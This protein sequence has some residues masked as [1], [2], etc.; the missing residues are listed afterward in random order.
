MDRD[1]NISVR[2]WRQK[3]PKAKGFF[4]THRLN[5]ISGSTSFLEMLDILNEQLIREGKEPVAFDNDCR[6]GICGMC[7]LYINGRPHGPDNLITTCQLH[8]RHFED[9]STIT[10]EPWRSAA[11]PVIRDLMVDRYAFDKIM[12]AGGYISVNTG[13]GARC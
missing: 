3:C 1:I 11:F 9:G 12:Q 8:M 4:E 5:N 13:G 10:V 6:E 2:V 7:S